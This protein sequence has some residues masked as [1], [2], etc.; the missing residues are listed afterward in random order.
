MA[1]SEPCE[2]NNYLVDHACLLRDS[3]FRLTGRKL[4]ENITDNIEFARALFEAP[5]VVMSHGVEADP[6]FNYANRRAMGLFEM[7]WET[8]TLLSSRYSAEPLNRAERQRLLEQVSSQGFI[9]NYSGVRIA[10]SGKR[11]CIE[12]AIV[13]NLV[14][15]QGVNHGQAAMFDRWTFL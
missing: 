3:F 4:L 14:D 1:F 12:Q 2:A 15:E 7:D 10:S 11:F 5:F 13:W 9:D 8:F 6:V